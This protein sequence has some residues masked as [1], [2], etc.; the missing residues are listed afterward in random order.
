VAGHAE[1]AA[2]RHIFVFSAALPLTTPFPAAV[3]TIMSQTPVTPPSN[4]PPLPKST[5]IHTQSNTTHKD[6]V[7][8]LKPE[9]REHIF[10]QLST[11]MNPFF[12]GPMPPH[13]FL[14]EFLPL[15]QLEPPFSEGMF[16][17][18][19]GVSKETDMYNQFVCFRSYLLS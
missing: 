10:G 19:I 17:S 15:S 11:K 4:V 6:G 3:F 8:G 7:Y 18:M 9:G 2:P 5:P 14:E 13:D 12:V 1:L 16:S